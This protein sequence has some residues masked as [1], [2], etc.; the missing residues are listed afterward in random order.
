[1][2][3]ALQV[4]VGSSRLLINMEK[5]GKKQLKKIKSASYVL[6]RFVAVEMRKCCFKIHFCIK[7]P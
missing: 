7:W 1:M 4:F 5:K 6:L 3:V 2:L